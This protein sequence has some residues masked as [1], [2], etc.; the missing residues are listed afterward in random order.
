MITTMAA[1][2]SGESDL[3]TSTL[4]RE[5]RDALTHLYDHAYL[6]R[7][8]LAAR[9]APPS[10]GPRTRA[11]AT[12]RILLDAIELLNPGDNVGLRA[13]ERRAYGILFGLY[14]EGLDVADVAEQLGISARQL[15]RDRAVAIEALAAILEDRHLPPAPPLAVPP[16]PPTEIP[17]PPVDAL[18]TESRR[19]AAQ[20]E[21]LD[22]AR[23]IANLL[24]ILTPLARER[25]VTLAAAIDPA[26]PRVRANPTLVRQILI[27]LARQAMEPGRAG[28]LSF[29]AA[30]GA[31]S[32]RVGLV[33]TPAGGAT[34]AP[35]L[36]PDS[37]LATMAA[38]LGGAIEEE[39]PATPA[40][41]G[42]RWLRLPY[43]AQRTVLIVDD[44]QDLLELFRR[45]LA[46]YP[47][48]VMAAGTVDEGLALLGGTRPDAVVLDLMMPG[49][50]GWEFLRAVRE[51]PGLQDLPVIVCS[52][53]HEPDLALAL[54][55][56]DVLKKPVAAADLLA[57]LTRVLGEG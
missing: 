38:A 12:R 34:T 27:G 11:Q 14:V 30:V 17:A 42:T 49:R 7:H 18:L 5:V 9:L 6:E 54:G 16:A 35:A 45:Y 55:A 4:A 32:I 22:L 13:L 23:L 10:G 24:P 28:R 20:P 36:P 37:D 48:Q 33:F 41:A 44:N 57:A 53:L 19:L 1:S 26:L 46:G 40:A 15:R 56:Q 31:G 25:Q 29:Q 52:V 2:E 8:P 21:A 3:P 43:R 47:Y 51:E 50:D 39:L